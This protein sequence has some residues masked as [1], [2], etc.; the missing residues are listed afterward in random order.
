MHRIGLTGGICTGKSLVLD[1]FKELGAYTVKADKIAKNLIF[2]KDSPIFLEI[3]KVFGNQI[4]NADN[5]INTDSF[6]KILFEDSEKRDFIN[7]IVQPY[8]IKE[9]D[10][11]YQS[12]KEKK[13]YDFFIYESALL[14]EAG[15]YKDFEK[16]IVVYT[17]PGEQIKRLIDRDNID[18]EFAEKKIKSQYPLS[19]KLKVAN[20]IIDTTGS[21]ENSKT[22]TLETFHL[23]KKDFNIQ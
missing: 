14:V 4:T 9:R 12:L 11:I 8:V 3:I 22:Q 13:L 20:Y 5:E 1:I 15:T 17:T 7:N 23:M 21:F 16:I 10:K 2:S 19:E 18:R 6:A